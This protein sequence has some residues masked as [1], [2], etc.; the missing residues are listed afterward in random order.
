[1]K[2]LL[3]IFILLQLYVSAYGQDS[4]YDTAED[5]FLDHQ[6]LQA[7][8]KY[9]QASETF[10]QKR[11][12][13]HYADCQLKMVKCHLGTGKL[14]EAL[15]LSMLTSDFVAKHL[16][17]QSYQGRC[18]LE[19][20]ISHF[21][22]GHN[23]KAIEQLQKTEPLLSTQPLDLAECYE[24]LG[25]AN[26][27]NGNLERSKG[28]HEKALQIREQSKDELLVADSYM[29]L[30]LLYIESDPAT[31]VDYFEKAL[32]H[33]DKLP[34]L[35]PKRAYLYTNL[36]FANANMSNYPMAMDYINRVEDIWGEKYTSDHPNK[37]FS[38]SNKGRLMA[39]LGDQQE[40]L[41]LQQEA[42][43]MYQALYG[44]KHP[45]IA[46]THYQIAEL[47]FN[48]GE[49]LE[50]VNEYQRAVYANLINQ[51]FE[52]IY[53]LP[54][55]DN[56]F[57]ANVLLYSMQAKAVAMEAYHFNR[58]LKKADA[59]NA[60][61]TYLLCDELIFE[62]RNIRV[63]EKEK[64]KLSEI[65]HD[66][67][68]NGV[69][70]SKYLSEHSFNKTYYK[71]LAFDFCER[72]KASVLQ[73]AI[74]DTKAKRFGSVLESDLNFEDSLKNE[75]S[76][77]ELLMAKETDYD[78]LKVLEQ[79]VFDYMT[80]LHQFTKDLESKYPA[81]YQ[82]KYDREDLD[83]E[84]LQG[85]LTED[86]AVLSYLI[87]EDEIYTLLVSKNS[88]DI[89]SSPLSRDFVKMIKGYRNSIKFR[90][91]GSF[92]RVSTEMY[93]LL[94]P[95]I[96]K[97]IQ[98]LV[99]IPD[100]MMATMPFEPLMNAESKNPAYLIE[101]YS[102]SYEYSAKLFQSKLEVGNV[103]DVEKKALLVAP[104]DFNKSDKRLQTLN[105]TL[106]EINDIKHILGGAEYSSTLISR[107]KAT[108]TMFKST[109]DKGYSY[110]HLATHGLADAKT[111]ELSRIFLTPTQ[112]DDGNLYAGEIYNLNLTAD[113]VTLSA[114][115]TGLG[116]VATG[117]GVIG[118]TRAMMYAGAS[119]VVVSL[120]SV[121]DQSTSQLMI[122]F[123]KNHVYHSN[124]IG[125]S[126]DLRKAK[127]QMIASEKYS[128]PY[129][130]APFVLIGN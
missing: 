45:E 102:I 41:V 88:I 77:R 96:P 38:K 97:N 107:E 54:V 18:M 50:A 118:L 48:Q 24:N 98:S 80:A 110:I 109:G 29:N 86:Q 61:E 87:N 16:T 14:R 26:W 12:P 114:C 5:L 68:I 130:W 103:E 62:M 52:T 121:S 13:N 71:Q 65:A 123:Y 122:D 69:E 95:K 40:A 93:N 35:S 94:I 90:D 63:S 53:D 55:L 58:S 120:W 84:K 129:Y 111:P 20:G 19:I 34:E 85:Q 7:F 32:T 44:T 92:E 47:Y 116:K 70:L 56:Y 66:V 113:I 36:A 89:S 3:S 74:N 11:D 127:I 67:Y 100:G 124:R 1:M 17:D 21:F 99:V 27:N 83:V 64:I 39:L 37:A 31:S 82:L 46:N 126:D 15:Q 73:E 23:Q 10:L 128:A 6:Y 60:L 75:I 42:L 115:Q 104:V 9:Q 30:G 78:R 79:E 101:D 117:E 72:S 59:D 49:Y 106:V 105:E 33:Y 108:E 28:Y 81:Y 119:N 91:Q 51:E 125:F 8:N 57:N 22:L 4:V 43:N 2:N 112:V 25:L 76:Y